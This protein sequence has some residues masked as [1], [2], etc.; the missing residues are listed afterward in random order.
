MVVIFIKEILNCLADVFHNV[1]ENTVKNSNAEDTD[2][3]KK[4]V[5]TL[6]CLL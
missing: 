1:Y 4:G 6:T 3:H 2:F 5:V